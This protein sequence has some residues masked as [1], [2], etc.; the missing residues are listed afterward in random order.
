MWKFP[1]K[2][3]LR[4]SS[5]TTTNKKPLGLYIHIPF[6]VHRCS[7]C[8][9]LS[10][11]DP[12]KDAV[13]TYI[14]ALSRQIG[15]F[16]AGFTRESLHFAADNYY[17]D[18]VYI[19]GGTPSFID[20]GHVARIMDELR[21]PFSFAGD[22]RIEGLPEIT[23]EANPES[24]TEEKLEAYLKA[25]IN[26][27]SIGVQSLNNEML[28]T[29]GRAH[30]REVFLRKY[31][32][33]K[34]AG[35]KNISLDLIFALPGQTLGDWEKTLGETISLD[36]Q[37]ISFYAL[38]IE[39]G[40]PLKEMIDTGFLDA[41]D[42]ETDRAMYHKA[43]GMLKA[44]GYVHYEISNCAKPGFQSRHNLKYWSMEE[45]LGL[46]LGAHSYLSGHRCEN[47]RELDVYLKGMGSG[48][49]MD[50]VHKNT[51]EDE[52]AE[53]M[54][55]GLRKVE[56]I[57]IK[58]FEQRFG[59]DIYSKYGEAIEKNVKAGLLKSDEKTIRLSLAGLDLFNRV[60]VDFV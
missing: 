21:T 36:P 5:M 32:M 17:I 47:V 37:H 42:E 56:G 29:L 50:S 40:T 24:I 28:N 54:F 44:A 1:R 25:G 2:L 12:G 15:S 48:D 9:F 45:Y 58:D 10:F 16:K 26:R 51:L 41:I 55:T 46:G 35:F 20:A 30:S 4:C 49:F 18:T 57:E 38:Q 59:M 34:N 60:L 22:G 23:I 53:Y 52:L 43:V 13:A 11:Q 8:D 39:E 6:C 27:L 3:L 33:A 7:Y 19:G 31:E 14:D